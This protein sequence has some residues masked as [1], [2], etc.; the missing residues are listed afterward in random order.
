[1]F[2]QNIVLLP[3]CVFRTP[4]KRMCTV[5]HPM[6]LFLCFF[7]RTRVLLLVDIF[8]WICLCS[9]S[10]L[11]MS[12][13]L[14]FQKQARRRRSDAVSAFYK[15]VFPPLKKQFCCPQTSSCDVFKYIRTVLLLLLSPRKHDMQA[16]IITTERRGRGG[17]GWG[18]A[19]VFCPPIV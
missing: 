14:T 19:F 1:M 10:W 4:H 16:S 12:S 11:C 6:F 17:K 18:R 2:F 7:M 13:S 9:V 8:V 3:A 5:Y 15:I